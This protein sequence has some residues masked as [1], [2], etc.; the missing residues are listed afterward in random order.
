DYNYP[1]SVNSIVEV[2]GVVPVSDVDAGN[3]AILIVVE[4]VHGG[5]KD[6]L[7]SSFN[8]E[9]QF[10]PANIPSCSGEEEFSV[11]ILGL[12]DAGIIDENQTLCYGD[13]AETIN[14]TT[15]GSGGGTISYRWESSTTDASSGF[16][17]IAGET[18]PTLS[19]GALTQ[20]TF[21]RRITVNNESG[22]TC[23]SLPTG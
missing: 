23:E 13:T 20:T 4:T 3:I 9:F 17:P 10:F 18:G 11:N 2:S 14:S 16:S 21:Y 12:P 15:D 5:D 8:A 1:V 19:P 6:W 22:I 7:L